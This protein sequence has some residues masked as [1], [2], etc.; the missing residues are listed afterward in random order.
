MHNEGYMDVGQV[1]NNL[2]RFL[3]EIAKEDGG[4]HPPGMTGREIRVYVE[5]G[6]VEVGVGIGVVEFTPPNAMIPSYE[7]S[8]KLWPL[9]ITRKGRQLLKVLQAQ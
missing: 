9:T 1:F 8:P 3:A 2:Q 6:L 5:H 7:Q 4:L